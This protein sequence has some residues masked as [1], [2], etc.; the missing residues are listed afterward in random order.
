MCFPLGPKTDLPGEGK[1][2]PLVC[3]SYY[4]FSF[5]ALDA[6]NPLK[7]RGRSRVLLQL[8]AT[9]ETWAI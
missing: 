8:F 3:P 4:F 2:P 5:N 7:L 6:A 1:L 9:F